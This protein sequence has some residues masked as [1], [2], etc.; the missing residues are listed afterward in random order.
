MKLILIVALSFFAISANA[1]TFLDTLNRGNELRVAAADITP[2]SDAP[3]APSR[4][5]VIQETEVVAAPK[6][7]AP[8]RPRTAVVDTLHLSPSSAV[9]TAPVV[10]RT[11]HAPQVPTPV[12]VHDTVAAPI[13]TAAT[14]SHDTT[15]TTPAT[16]VRQKTPTPAPVT[17]AKIVMEPDEPT[18]ATPAA[19]T[20]PVPAKTARAVPAAPASVVAEPAAEPKKKP[21]KVVLVSA[22]GFRIQ[23]AACRMHGPLDDKVDEYAKKLRQPCY[24]VPFKDIYKLYTG[25]YRTKV[26]AVKDLPRIKG[27]FPDAWVVATDIVTPRE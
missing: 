15:Y 13:K 6:P 20:A 21:A 23:L 18:D 14:V 22:T 17:P 27:E 19:E 26:E 9:P 8:V 11:E 16:P 1:Q 7:A 2:S 12:V 25:N 3:P 24:V 10:A 5:P 4:A